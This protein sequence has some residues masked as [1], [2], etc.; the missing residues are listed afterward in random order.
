MF[1]LMM[2]TEVEKPEYDPLMHQHAL[3]IDGW[4]MT[5]DYEYCHCGK[6]LIKC[7]SAKMEMINAY[8]AYWPDR[9][10]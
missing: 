6:T 10:A 2:L 4:L 7:P 5:Q 8:N 9:P 1:E 3:L